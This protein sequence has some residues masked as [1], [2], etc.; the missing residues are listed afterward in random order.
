MRIWDEID[1]CRLCTKHLAGEHRE[2]HGAYAI[3]TDP[4][5]KLGGNY[6]NHQETKRWYGRADALKI[7]HDMLVE[8]AARRGLPM[9]LDH[10]TPLHW[11]GDKSEFPKPIDNQVVELQKKQCSC[12][13]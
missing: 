3:I 8:E 9:G 12:K 2:L 11:V 7:R 4:D 6:R 13:M 1:P 10:K 5:E